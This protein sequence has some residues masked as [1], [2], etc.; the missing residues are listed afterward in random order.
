MIQVSS[1]PPHGRAGVVTWDLRRGN[2]TPVAPRCYGG[3]A[4][5]L[6]GATAG[7]QQLPLGQMLGPPVVFP[8]GGGPPCDPVY[9]P[10][11]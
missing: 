4:V 1:P 5:V 10:L 2:E 6:G 11:F 9:P 8:A 3:F 7:D